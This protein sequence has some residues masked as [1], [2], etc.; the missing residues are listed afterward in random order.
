MKGVRRTKTEVQQGD[1]QAKESAANDFEIHHGP[2]ETNRLL[3]NADFAKRATGQ[4]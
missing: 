3:Q 1:D 4:L 2:R